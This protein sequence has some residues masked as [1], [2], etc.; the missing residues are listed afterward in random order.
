MIPTWKLL[1]I[2]VKEPQ[3]GNHASLSSSCLDTWHP[4]GVRTADFVV[5]FLGHTSSLC[6]DVFVLEGTAHCQNWQLYKAHAVCLCVPWTLFPHRRP[7]TKTED[8]SLF[9]AML[10]DRAPAQRAR[11]L[12][13]CV[14]AVGRACCVGFITACL[15][16]RAHPK[17]VAPFPSSRLALKA[18]I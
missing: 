2:L 3:T 10:T 1:M 7:S 17:P 13:C 18:Q 9:L 5:F 11:T 4:V 15:E 12:Q 6:P 8:T 16:S 14:W